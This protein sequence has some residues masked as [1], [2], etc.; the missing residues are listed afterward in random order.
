MSSA[1]ACPGSECSR[2]QQ[3]L[4]NRMVASL[5]TSSISGPMLSG[6]LRLTLK[7]LCTMPSSTQ[8]AKDSLFHA[9]VLLKLSKYCRRFDQQQDRDHAPMSWSSYARCVSTADI[10]PNHDYFTMHCLNLLREFH[11]SGRSIC[12]YAAACHVHICQPHCA[13]D[14]ML[15]S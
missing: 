7:Q 2:N 13:T 11:S 15:T 10:G 8:Q 1:R 3:S 9:V 12:R 4:Q 5:A 14:S 6:L